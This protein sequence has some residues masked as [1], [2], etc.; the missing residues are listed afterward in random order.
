MLRMPPECQV[1]FILDVGVLEPDF[2]DH[3]SYTKLLLANKD[4]F[5]INNKSN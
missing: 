5:T 3:P 2:K 4:A 1:N